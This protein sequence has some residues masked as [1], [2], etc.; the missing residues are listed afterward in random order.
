M[1]VI[2]LSRIDSS[3]FS[4]QLQS[5]VLFSRLMKLPQYRIPQFFYTQLC[6]LFDIS[7]SR[8]MTRVRKLVTKSCLVPCLSYIQFRPKLQDCKAG[9]LCP[10][11][12]VPFCCSFGPI[13]FLN[14][15]MTAP[16]PGPYCNTYRLPACL[17]NE[18]WHFF[19]QCLV[20]FI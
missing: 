4:V 18:L 12:C 15:S 14:R 13:I 19:S 17:Q 9:T 3:C 1:G 2:L 10:L 16:P 7:R 6:K 11:I 8:I 20:F 5:M